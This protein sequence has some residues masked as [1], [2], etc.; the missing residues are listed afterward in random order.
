MIGTDV[1]QRSTDPFWMSGRKCKG[2]A[3]L[4]YLNLDFIGTDWRDHFSNFRGSLGLPF[5][6]HFG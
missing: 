2:K 6:S 4:A 5:F 1:R 3:P